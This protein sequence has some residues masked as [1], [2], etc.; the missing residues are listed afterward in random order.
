VGTTKHTGH[1]TN[2]FTGSVKCSHSRIDYCVNYH[3]AAAHSLLTNI[4]FLLLII[5]KPFTGTVPVSVV[6]HH[7]VFSVIQ[8]DPPDWLL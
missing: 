8:T 5:L 6:A 7:S 1:H 3:R 2:A 4:I